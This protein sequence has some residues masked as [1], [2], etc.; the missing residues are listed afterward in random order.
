MNAMMKCIC[1]NDYFY[2]CPNNKFFV[3]YHENDV[4]FFKK[5]EYYVNNQ[6]RDC[7]IAK[8]TTIS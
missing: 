3:T 5:L 4:N 8:N 1:H 6:C 7:D 2:K